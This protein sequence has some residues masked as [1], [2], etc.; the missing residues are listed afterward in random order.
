MGSRSLAH[1]QFFE[2]MQRGSSFYLL[3]MDM[4]DVEDLQHY[5]AEKEDHCAEH[6][7]A[8][9]SDPDDTTSIERLEDMDREDPTNWTDM[10][11]LD[12]LVERVSETAHLISFRCRS[13][14]LPQLILYH[15]TSL[16]ATSGSLI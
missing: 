8:Q 5:C 10:E 3:P 16:P 11:M 15:R 9:E 12:Y 13:H 4:P 14:V 6:F 2:Q 1:M 7:A